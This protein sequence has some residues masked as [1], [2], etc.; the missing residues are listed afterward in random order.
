VAFAQQHELVS[1]FYEKPGRYEERVV[2]RAPHPNWGIDNLSAVDFDGDSE[3][4]TLEPAP[5]I[6]I[7]FNEGPR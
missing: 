4:E 6:E 7:F 3:A 5:S 1:L 2:Y